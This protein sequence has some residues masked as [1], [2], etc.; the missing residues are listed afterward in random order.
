M[1]R[2]GGI[3]YVFAGDTLIGEVTSSGAQVAYT[4]SPHG[5]ISERILTGTAA[6]YWYHFGP[7]GETRYLTNSLGN[8]TNTYR[9]DAYGVKLAQTGTVAN[10]FRYG[11]RFGYYTDSGLN[12]MLAGARWYMP[13]LARWM[14][15]D[16]IKYDGGDNVYSYVM[17]N[18]VRWVD[19]TGLIHY[20]NVPPTTVPP[21][22]QTMQCLQCTEDCLKLL[23]DKSNLDLLINGGSETTGHSANSHHYLGE[24]VDIA[25]PNYNPVNDSQVKQCAKQCGFNNGHFKNGSNPPNTAHWHLQLHSGNG[26]EPL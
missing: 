3:Y 9:Y 14:S 26:V 19:P 12:L 1:T 7:Q 21:T 13:Q 5:L 22:G 15:K 2:S 6:T 23:T 4:Q 10:P 25:G 11:G 16:P 24:A 18:P 8:I 17:Q 20:N